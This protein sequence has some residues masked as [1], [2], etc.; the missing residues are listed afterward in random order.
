MVYLSGAGL[1]GCPGKRP[2]NECSSVAVA[3][4]EKKAF[5]ELSFC[6]KLFFDSLS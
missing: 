6:A 1:P 5:Y 2:L 3:V 4:Y